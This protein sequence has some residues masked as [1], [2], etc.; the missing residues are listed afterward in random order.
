MGVETDGERGAD[1]C[2][3][4]ERR[5]VR[6]ATRWGGAALV[7]SGV[8]RRGGGQSGQEAG[9]KR[10]PAPV[11]ER[12]DSAKAPLAPPPGDDPD[13]RAPQLFSHYQGATHGLTA[14]NHLSPVPPTPSTCRLPSSRA[15]VCLGAAARNPA[16]RRRW[17]ALQSQR[18]IRH[19]SPA[20]GTLALHSR[21]PRQLQPPPTQATPSC[22]TRVSP[23]LQLR[24][25]W[26]RSRTRCPSSLRTHC[27]IVSAVSGTLRTQHC[28]HSRDQR[29]VISDC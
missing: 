19:F 23:M 18:P 15:E 13:S 27:S 8:W 2:G 11:R 3:G 1:T 21:S 25:G 26:A 10:R 29:P 17:T 7:E 22:L 9:G 20:A 16:S 12:P 5:T 6:V 4:E 28:R 14:P 24:A